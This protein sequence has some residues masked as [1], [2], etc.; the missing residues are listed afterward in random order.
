M[1]N[2]VVNILSFEGDSVEIKTM[3]EAIRPDKTEDESPNIDFNKIIPMP[4]ELNIESSTSVD[5]GLEAYV[6]FISDFL[7]LGR[8]KRACLDCSLQTLESEIR[9]SNGISEKEW[10]LGKKALINL[11]KHGSQDWYGWRC[12]HW[13]TK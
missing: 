7:K 4:E 9:E 6:E 10:E 11:V 1:P 3:L 2:H 5:K 12:E 8:Y 13:G